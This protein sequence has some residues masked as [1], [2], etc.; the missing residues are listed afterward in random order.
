MMRNQH[1]LQCLLLSICSMCLCSISALAAYGDWTVHAAYHNASKVVEFEGLI[2]VLSDGGLYSYDPDDTTVETYDKASLL[3]DNGIFD[4]VSNNATHQ[5]VIIYTNGN[6]DLLNA[7]GQLYNMPDL[8]ETSALA[9]K[10]INSVYVSGSDVYISTN[11]GIVVLDTRRRVISNTYNFGHIVSS[12]IIDNGTIIAVTPDGFYTGNL[13]DNLLDAN[14]WKCKSTSKFQKIF[15]VEGTYFIIP[16]WLQLRYISDKET[17]AVGYV[18]SANFTSFSVI[19]G[20]LFCFGANEIVTV[21]KDR[22]IKRYP[23]PGIVYVCKT[24]SN[25]WA[26]CGTEGLKGYKFD[27][28]DGFTPTVSSVIPNS[29]MRNYFYKLQMYDGRLLSV[30]GCLEYPAVE[31]TFTVMKYEN[32]EW[33]TFEEEPLHSEL[34]DFC[35][36]N[37]FS[38]VQDPNDSEHHYVGGS[39]GIV[40]YKDYKYVNLINHTNSPLTSI[41]PDDHYDNFYVRTT[42]LNYDSQH[43]LWMFNNECDTVLR[44]LGADGRWIAYYSEAIAGHPA[45]DRAIFDRRGWA[46]INSRM[47]G[48]SNNGGIYV[49]D[50]NGTLHQRSDDHQRFIYIISN[51]DGT[52]YQF[53]NLN[54]I[55]E[56][57]D[58]A[59]WIGCNWGPFV[60]YE[61][62]TVFNTDFYFTQPKV[63]RNDGT[64]YADYLLSEVEVR[65]IA[66]DGANR[67]WFGTMGNGVYLTNADG[68]AILQHFT[69]DNSPLVS[70]D[71]YDIAIDGQ[72]G[73]VF[74]ATTRGL[75]SYMS[76]AT[77]PEEQFD[78][79][80]VRVYPNPVRPDYQGNIIVRG[81]MSD[82]DVKIVNAAGRLVHQ[83]I[84]NG[85]QFTWD[86]RIS[87]GKQAAS[88]V[89][90]VLATDA[91]GN[92]GA[93]AKFVIVR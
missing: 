11:S 24:G 38:I 60:T 41:L 9:D 18:D 20:K 10:T 55:V 70:N 80:L 72:S 21:D 33:T 40:E 34:G 2:Y 31:R 46:W 26:A 37:A 64:N 83:G 13:S 22:N 30:G 76:D 90:Y 43:N 69:A 23:N 92:K 17:L 1:I 8:K 75:V 48:P 53:N 4:I 93:A 16:T 32:H 81:L 15:N 19:D 3:S 78:S 87:G 59:I 58:G 74:F 27:D 6:I 61:P 73:E 56:D 5:L 77:N 89:Y 42:G 51:Q 14:N 79:D 84:S 45:F 63:P 49:L 71:I 65:C 7:N 50:T 29:P 35:F 36:R 67:K 85:G 28:T 54:C 68:S 86:G 39:I 12:I 88:G 44:I 25:Y 62:S 91:D 52:S 57:L 47:S 82:T 66:V